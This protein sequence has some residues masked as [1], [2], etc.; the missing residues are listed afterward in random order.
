M[1]TPKPSE[2][3]IALT[4]PG[5]L[6]VAAILLAACV[7]LHMTVAA[8]KLSFQ[9]QPVELQRPLDMLPR[10]I[11]PWMMLG[12]DEVMPAEI[13]HA[14][15]TKDYI[16]RRYFDT[17]LIEKTDMDK[18]L[19][20]MTDSERDG[21]IEKVFR[22]KP[23]SLISIHMAYYTNKVDTV[24]HVPERCM[25]GGGF[26]PKNPSTVKLN[27][28]PDRPDRPAGLNVKYI[29]FYQREPQGAMVSDGFRERVLNVAYFFQVNGAYE[30]ESVTG[31]RKRLQSLSEKFAYYC[32]IELSTQLD[33]E[34]GKASRTMEDFLRHAMPQIEKCLPDW[35]AVSGKDPEWNTSQ[36]N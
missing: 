2:P 1:T 21:V 33:P 11:G 15:G 6:V 27:V 24:A 3:V 35:K 18:P 29:D 4:R 34:S 23:E 26:D 5:F 13:E 12:Q 14:L 10:Q 32:K 16:Q 25:S 7:G 17:R 20:K 30:S 22:R 28:F 31:A 19:A 9:K 8:M 36:A